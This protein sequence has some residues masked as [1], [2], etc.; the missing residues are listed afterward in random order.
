MTCAQCAHFLDD[1]AAI[2]AM[3]PGLTAM[4]SA[5]ASVRGDDGLCTAHDRMASAR[6]WCERFAPRV[7]AS[8]A[9]P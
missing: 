3:I 4:G 6:D 1:P 9:R 2:E 5:R 7:R 8:P